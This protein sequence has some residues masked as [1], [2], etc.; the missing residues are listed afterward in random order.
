[1]RQLRRTFVA[2]TLLMTTSI[3]ARSL[4]AL[5]Q[6]HTGMPDPPSPADPQQRDKV[7]AQDEAKTG[8]SDI[9][10]RREKEYRSD[11]EKLF[12]WANELREEARNTPGIQVLSVKTLKKL[13]EIEK[14]AKRMQ[15]EVKG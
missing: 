14:L 2:S 11:T 12:Q 15:K 5:D 3:L 4:W 10:L 1:M 13:Q 7:A 8:R 9:L 6:H